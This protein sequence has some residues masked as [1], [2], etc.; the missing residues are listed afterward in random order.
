MSRGVC[1]PYNTWDAQKNSIVPLCIITLHGIT[2]DIMAEEG[3]EFRD[4]LLQMHSIALSSPASVN[5]S[6]ASFAES[7]LIL[8]GAE[9]MS[10]D[11]PEASETL[12]QNLSIQNNGTPRELHTYTPWATHLNWV[13]IKREG[14]RGQ[15]HD[16]L[17]IPSFVLP[18]GYLHPKKKKT[19][20]SKPGQAPAAAYVIAALSG[21]EDPSVIY[22]KKNDRFL[23]SPHAY[24]YVD[25]RNDPDHP[26]YLPPEKLCQHQA[27]EIFGYSVWRH[28][29]QFLRCALPSCHATT[30]DHDVTTQIC[31]GCGIPSRL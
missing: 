21:S 1:I 23:I 31:H 25:L 26:D 30:V 11:E 8:C 5:S 24:P 15:K 20:K 9:D 12:Q 14:D 6:D 17:G 2:T 18:C 28:D 27:C 4:G 7:H 19:S 16:K 29:R 13:Y 3:M 22:D 10:D